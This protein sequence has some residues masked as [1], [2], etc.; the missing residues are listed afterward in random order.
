MTR[1]RPLVFWPVLLT[2]V[3]AVLAWSI[4]AELIAAPGSEVWSIY[5]Y[6]RPAQAP[7]LRPVATSADPAPLPPTPPA[8][9]FTLPA[10]DA[11][12]SVLAR[13]MFSTSRRPPAE[14]VAVAIATPEPTLDLALRGV[15]LSSDERIALIVPAARTEVVRLREGEQFQGWTLVVVEADHV[16]FR[17]DVEEL[18]F[19]LNFDEPIPEPLQSPRRRPRRQ[20]RN[21]P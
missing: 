14:T 13:P 12:T 7:D 10:L 18:I 16:V 3:S 1:R 21:A 11:F 20:R 15:I 6:L 4:Y 2:A 17:L 9:E 19:E 5:E 8:A